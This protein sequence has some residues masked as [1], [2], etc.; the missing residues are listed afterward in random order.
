MS[1]R[2]LK[3]KTV[4]GIGWS[5]I[6]NVTRLG[7][8]FV[9][10]IVLA[11][12]LSPEEY[13]LIGILTIFISV[14]N[15]IIDSGFTNALIRKQNVTDVDYSTVFYTNLILSIV[16]AT[17]LF[18]CANPIAVFFERP[19]LFSLTRVM[20]CVLVINALAIVQRART[21]KALDF[22]VQTKI[23]LISSVASGN[24]RSPTRSRSSIGLI[25]SIYPC[26]TQP[27]LCHSTPHNP[28]KSM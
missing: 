12:L 5:V 8:T 16:L 23:T 11:R 10:S 18:F 9:V 4:I 26:C 27:L 7:V 20:S 19:E 13:G 14:F 21:I 28:F 1:E 2:S 22:K 6:E 15:A 25:E 17:T 24:T 3:D